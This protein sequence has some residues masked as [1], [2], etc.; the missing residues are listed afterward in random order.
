VRPEDRALEQWARL[1]A[2]GV[3]EFAIGYGIGTVAMG[4]RSATWAGRAAQ[5]A[6]VFDTTS[7]AVSVGRGVRG[8]YNDGANFGNIAPG[9]TGLLDFSKENGCHWLLA[10]SVQG[11]RLD[12]M[13]C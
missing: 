7:N 12:Q 5:A 2:R 4:A 13:E 9:A 6:L 10:A 3:T 1:F 8:L 11:V